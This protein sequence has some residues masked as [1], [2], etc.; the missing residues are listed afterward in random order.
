MA[1]ETRI[2]QATEQAL[3]V[4]E[5]SRILTLKQAV[6][7]ALVVTEPPYRGVRGIQAL[8]SVL[9][10][11]AAPGGSPPSVNQVGFQVLISDESR[12]AVVGNTHKALIQEQAPIIGTLVFQNT[13]QALVSVE[14]PITGTPVLQVLNRTLVQTD[15]PAFGSIAT[16]VTQK[17]LLQVEG[18]SKA[19]FVPGVYQT[20]IFVDTSTAS[21][22]RSFGIQQKALIVQEPAS[23]NDYRNRNIIS[24]VAKSVTMPLFASIRSDAIVPSVVVQSARPK[25][26]S[27]NVQSEALVTQNTLLT[28]TSAHPVNPQSVKS[29]ATVATTVLEYARVKS[30]ANPGLAQS[31]SNVAS[32]VKEVARPVTKTNPGSIQSP[33]VIPQMSLEYAKAKHFDTAVVSSMSEV[34]NGSTLVAVASTYP[35]SAMS[36]SLV[37]KVS[38]S[39]A[40][41]AQYPNMDDLRSDVLI[42]SV[43]HV[44]SV[45]ADSYIQ[46]D[47]ITAATLMVNVFVMTSRPRVSRDPNDE[48]S[49]TMVQ[50]KSI[51]VSRPVVP[52]NPALISP[53]LKFVHGVSNLLAMRASYFDPMFP[54][55][56]RRDAYGTYYTVLDN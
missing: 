50:N 29:N 40:K 11:E 31:M 20:T 54:T 35:E 12:T 6:H 47:L 41:V 7:T 33:A 46:P 44:T 56:A 45:K 14:P 13:H 42:S 5:P 48:R 39:T 4:Q 19:V 3:V 1:G 49:S 9:I 15:A 27:L 2:S 25:T 43:R 36:D 23:S 51:L 32:I 17:T 16:Q 22:I 52:T 21:K 24:S 8:E 38:R 53:D 34:A 18:P 30:S 28:A 10:Q 26:F 37:K 55:N